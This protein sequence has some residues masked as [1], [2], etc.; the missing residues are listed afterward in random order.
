MWCGGADNNYN[1]SMIHYL[2]G[3]KNSHYTLV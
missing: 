1:H 2:K 3:Q